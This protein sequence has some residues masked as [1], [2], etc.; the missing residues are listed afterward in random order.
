MRR[1]KHKN[2]KKQEL[3][4]EIEKQELAEQETK[5][6]NEEI[7]DPEFRSFFQDVLKKISTKNIY[8]HNECFRNF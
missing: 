8:G 3:F 7:E 6:L 4:E 1:K 5:Q 2:K